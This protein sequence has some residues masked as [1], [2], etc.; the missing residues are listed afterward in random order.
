MPPL[1][2]EQH[3]DDS[4][5]Q[6]DLAKAFEAVLLGSTTP[7]P[8][9][10]QAFRGYLASLNLEETSLLLPVIKRAF[11]RNPKAACAPGLA[12]LGGFKVP[13]DS[14]LAE[15][16]AS[17]QP[18]LKI[19]SASVLTPTCKLL[20][21]QVE[22]GEEG[23]AIEVVKAIGHFSEDRALKEICRTSLFDLIRSLAPRFSAAAAEIINSLLTSYKTLSESSCSVLCLL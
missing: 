2:T 15:I 12:A 19:D 7:S 5:L 20:R 14:L 3:P 22:T 4:T 18:A 16:F 9:A 6:A 17:V 10:L 1:T 11:A 21:V 23:A 13:L 8:L